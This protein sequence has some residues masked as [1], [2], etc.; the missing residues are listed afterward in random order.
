M[1][2]RIEITRPAQRQLRSLDQRTRARIAARVDRLAEDPRP[3]GVKR[4]QAHAAV[5]YRIRVGDHRVLYEA[6]DRALVVLIVT[7]GHRREVC[8]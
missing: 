7:I 2:F 4:L 8:R 5:L 1:A 3:R 6:D